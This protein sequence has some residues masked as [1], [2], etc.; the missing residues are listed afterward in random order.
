MGNGLRSQKR[1]QRGQLSHRSHRSSPIG[2]NHSGRVR[3]ASRA[4]H[5]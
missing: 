4:R 5:N 3:S 1:H 2:R